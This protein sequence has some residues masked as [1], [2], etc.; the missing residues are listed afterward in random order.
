MTNQAASRAHGQA[1]EVVQGA[2]FARFH[3][4]ARPG[5]GAPPAGVLL[6][7]GLARG[8][9]AQLVVLLQ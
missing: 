5:V 7:L 2:R 3:G 1:A 4:E 8:H 9:P 6:L